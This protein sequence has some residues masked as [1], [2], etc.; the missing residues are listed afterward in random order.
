MGFTSEA[1]DSVCSQKPLLLRAL[2]RTQSQCL[3]GPREFALGPNEALGAG[4]VLKGSGP[5]S[6][7]RSS[8]ADVSWGWDSIR[9]RLQQ[10]LDV[11]WGTHCQEKWSQGAWQEA[12]APS[13]RAPP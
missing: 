3:Q 8:T 11:G 5:G 12:W 10:A 2:K 1:L 6:D 4:A 7:S 9:E 13:A